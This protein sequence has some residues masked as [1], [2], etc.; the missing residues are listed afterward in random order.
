MEVGFEKEHQVT[1]AIC[2]S[3]LPWV[4]EH[5]LVNPVEA[6]SLVDFAG[7]WAGACHAV[8]PFTAQCRLVAELA[9]K[10]NVTNLTVYTLDQLGNRPYSG[11][12]ALLISAVVHGAVPRGTDLEIHPTRISRRFC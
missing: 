7:R 4:Q 1:V 3:Q 11:D 5:A 6:E 2:A 9:W 12:P 8:S 10:R